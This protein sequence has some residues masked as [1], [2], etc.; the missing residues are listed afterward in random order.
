MKRQ[1]SH[2]QMRSMHRTFWTFKR[3]RLG[4]AF[5]TDR[6][7]R[8]RMLSILD[9][10][11]RNTGSGWRGEGNRLWSN[12]RHLAVLSEHGSE[13]SSRSKESKVGREEI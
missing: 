7:A 12:P 6:L 2:L 1:F 4:A 9:A 11:E 8:F 10:S 3:E 5:V 13:F